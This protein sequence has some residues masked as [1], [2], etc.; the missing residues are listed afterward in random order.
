VS[1]HALGD[2][3]ASRS[4]RAVVLALAGS[5]VA[6]ATATEARRRGKR[7]RRRTP[8]QMFADD[9]AV[10]F[11][12]LSRVRIEL[13][14][15]NSER[16]NLSLG[17]TIETGDQTGYNLKMPVSSYRTDLWLYFLPRDASEV[18][19][20][21]C[22]NHEVGRPDVT[23]QRG[24]FTAGRFQVTRNLADNVDMAEDTVLDVADGAFL[25]RVERQ[26][27]GTIGEDGHDEEYCRFIVSVTNR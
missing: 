27:D 19:L 23:V 2:S 10:K 20:V 1:G 8:P 11:R 18:Y 6:G 15:H 25:I 24:T 17:S 7:K 14:M 4:R 22:E 16:R 21:W 3:V 9:V 26:S 13:G 12:N 5:V